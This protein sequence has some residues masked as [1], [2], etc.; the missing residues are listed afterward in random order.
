MNAPGS[1]MGIARNPINP[2]NT[3]DLAVLRRVPRDETFGASE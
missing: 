1:F 3:I 2:K